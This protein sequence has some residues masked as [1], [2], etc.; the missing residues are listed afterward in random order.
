M[1][2]PAQLNVTGSVN[3]DMAREVPAI[4]QANG[5]IIIDAAMH[6]A[7]VR[8]VETHLTP[9]EFQ[10]LLILT[11]HSGKLV[12][13]STLREMF[14]RNPTARVGSLRV[15]VGALQNRSW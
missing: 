12:K 4:S 3:P 14:W 15:L 6:R 8:G 5:R 11:T 9:S 10:L 1:D 7:R 2:A 13:S